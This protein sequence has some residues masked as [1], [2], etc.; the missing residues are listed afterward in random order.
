MPPDASARHSRIIDRRPIVSAHGARNSDPAAMPNSPALSSSP[1][2]E[3]D[4]P[5]SLDT[6]FAVKAPNPLI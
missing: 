6:E 1:S 4:R 2:A 5:H 3:P